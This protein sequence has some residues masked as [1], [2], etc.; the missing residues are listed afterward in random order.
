MGFRV[1]GVTE[2]SLTSD[3]FVACLFQHSCRGLAGL[4][5]SAFP[6]ICR[7][8]GPEPVQGA[9]WKKAKNVGAMAEGFVSRVWGILIKGKINVHCAY[10]ARLEASAYAAASIFPP[11]PL[12]L[13]VAGLGCDKGPV[14]RLRLLKLA[15][16]LTGARLE[17]HVGWSGW[18]RPATMGG[19]S[20]KGEYTGF[21]EGSE[22]PEARRIIKKLELARCLQQRKIFI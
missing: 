22:R 2:A 18:T 13:R 15:N 1:E 12:S 10:L 19:G 7:S 9:S 6:Q 14:L 8:W 11:P 17:F 21:S 4:S 16:S 20:A 3:V 5:P